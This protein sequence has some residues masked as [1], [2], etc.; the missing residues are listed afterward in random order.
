[1]PRPENERVMTEK[2]LEFQYKTSEPVTA[3]RTRI[4]DCVEGISLGFEHYD[5][6]HSKGPGLYVAIISN[7]S[8][9]PFAEPMGSNRWPTETCPVIDETTDTFYPAAKTVAGS[10]DGGVCVGVDGT[11][12]EQMVRFKNVRD[13][14]LPAGVSVSDLEYADWMGARHMSAYETSLRPDVV[15]T[16]T[17]SEE[18]G[19]I[20]VFE[21]GEYET[22]PRSRIGD[23]WRGKGSGDTEQ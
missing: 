1:M 17:L 7:R 6:T 11:I 21:D 19:R 13:D 2:L 10:Q 20:T 4:Y 22:I 15:T 14:E 12:L 8:V 18:T 16:I 3:L 23:P 5:E 9:A